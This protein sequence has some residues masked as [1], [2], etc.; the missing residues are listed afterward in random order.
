MR[1]KEEF[2]SKHRRTPVVIYAFSGVVPPIAS[3]VWISQGRCCARDPVCVGPRGLLHP[4]QWNHCFLFLRPTAERI[5][6]CRPLVLAHATMLSPY[7]ICSRGSHISAVDSHHAPR[8]APH[9]LGMSYCLLLVRLHTQ[10]D[11]RSRPTKWG[12][13]WVFCHPHTLLPFLL[14]QLAVM[15][16]RQDRKQLAGYLH[17]SAAG[18]GWH[19]LIQQWTLGVLEATWISEAGLGS[20]Q[21]SFLFAKGYCRLSCILARLSYPLKNWWGASVQTVL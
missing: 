18:L 21:R 5:L 17:L 8:T 3:Y 4:V 12:N 9:T 7:M 16:L 14:G 19:G 15:V 20:W 13:N 11:W 10:H 6:K 1:G 2:L